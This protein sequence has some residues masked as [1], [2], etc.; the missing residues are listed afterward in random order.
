MSMFTKLMLSLLPMTQS[1]KE[2][3]NKME[4]TIIKETNSSKYFSIEVDE[5][6]DIALFAVDSYCKVLNRN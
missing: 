5:S 2:I 3:Y 4:E 1:L 6:T